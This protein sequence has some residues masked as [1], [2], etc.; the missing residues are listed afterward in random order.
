MDE[1]TAGVSALERVASCSRM[2]VLA[3]A[4]N[5]GARTLRVAASPQSGQAI[6]SGTAAIG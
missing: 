4:P 5:A 6:A 2:A 3:P 1:T